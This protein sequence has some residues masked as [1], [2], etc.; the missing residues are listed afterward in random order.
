LR[1]FAAFLVFIHHLGFNTGRTFTWWGGGVLDHL[2]VGVPV[3]FAIS[4][5]LLYRPHVMAALDDGVSPDLVR[6]YQRRAV[7]IYVPWW[8]AFLGTALVFDVAASMR[9]WPLHLGL[10]HIYSGETFFTGV[11]Q[12]WT[13][14]VEVTF[15]LLLPAYAAGLR[16]LVQG[17]PVDHRGLILLGGT[18]GLY[19]ISVLYRLAVYATD[20]SSQVVVL[21]GADDRPEVAGEIA[22]YWLPGMLDYFAIGMAAAVI[23]V[24]AERRDTVR[25]LAAALGTRPWLWWGVAALSLVFVSNQLR[26]PRGLDRGAWTSEMYEQFLYGVIAACL[27]VPA[28]FAGERRWLRPLATRPL[29]WCGAISY[30]FYLWHVQIIEAVLDWTDTAKFTGAFWQTGVL[31]LLVTGA[32]AAAA[33][34][35]VEEPAMR[36]LRARQRR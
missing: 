34:H 24:W 12:S 4:G 13:L 17:R 20:F 2:D 28:V 7:R 11:T 8:L 10:V 14:A 33:Y 26:L 1:A 25:P 9:Q 15:Y 6:Y 16:R 29:V 3:F 32:I 27:L 22:T 19:L 23:A 36:W 5:F 31:S 30:G 18:I 21:P 35:L